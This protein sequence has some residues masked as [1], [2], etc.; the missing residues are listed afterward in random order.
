MQAVIVGI[1]GSEYIRL[2]N[3]KANAACRT[4]NYKIYVSTFRIIILFEK[5]YWGVS[6]CYLQGC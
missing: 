1:W 5:D 4:I 3:N 2:A 6:I